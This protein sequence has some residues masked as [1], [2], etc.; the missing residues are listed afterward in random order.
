ME[1]KSNSNSKDK[2]LTHIA[3]TFLIEASGSFLN[4]GGLGVGE[5]DNYTVVKTFKDGQSSK[6]YYTVPFISA[7][8]WRRWLRDT[9]IEETGLKP[10]TIRA[11][12]KNPKGNT[13]KIG[14]ERDPIEYIED[15]V[16]GYMYPISKAE[17]AINK[18]EAEAEAG[19]E[20]E[21]DEDETIV[22]TESEGKGN[23]KEA[24]TIRGL[25]RTSTLASSI[26]RGLRK[27]GW[28]GRDQNYVSL[29]EGSSQPYKTQFMNTALQGVFD[30]HYD[31]LGLFSNIGDRAE[32][33]QEMINKYLNSKMLIKRQ[34]Q[35]EYFSLEKIPES[36]AAA[37]EAKPQPTKQSAAEKTS[38][39][40]PKNVRFDA[41]KKFGSIYEL[42]NAAQIRKERATALLKSLVVLR[43]G[44]KQAA[45]GT[46]VSPK[47]IIMAG[48]TCGNPIFNTLFEDNSI[49]PN[50]GKNVV[51][52]IEA[53]KE[54]ITD[55]KDRICTPVIIGIRTGYM[56]NE[57]KIRELDGMEVN[58]SGIKLVVTT[59]VDAAKQ[60]T[61]L[62]PDGT[63]I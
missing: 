9:L 57:P 43:G 44:A 29:I 28:E 45:F 21:G 18:A 41:I 56:Q 27:D 22:E 20:T 61:D 58:G 48:M 38:K 36:A 55:Y 25:F 54:V 47:V 30:L 51:L 5:Y 1:G 42:T 2:K 24:M 14:S 16:F 62:L 35:P 31:R 3:G 39:K 50:M 34:D 32:L 63:S 10:S 26:L 37:A 17:A 7:A 33:D 11:L 12:H 4:G 19:T 15:D 46:D 13:D 49:N 6:G 8:S 53:L 40:K 52:N 59:P 60:M 23:G